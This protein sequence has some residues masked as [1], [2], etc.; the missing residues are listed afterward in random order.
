MKKNLL[1]CVTALLAASL[2]VVAASPKDDEVTE[3]AKKLAENRTTVGKATVVVPESAQFRP[4]PTEGKIEKDGFAHLTWSFNDNT[5]QA[6][7]RG[8]KGAATIRR[9]LAIDLRI[10]E[11]R[12]LRALYR[13]ALRNFKAPARKPRNSPP[14]PKN[15]RRM[16]TPMPGNSLRRRRETQ[17]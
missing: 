13:P 11:Q 1:F 15:P 5:S 6:S 4:G 17:L 9:R 12:R 16:G 10:G 14:S 7:S 3:A 2:N 8:D